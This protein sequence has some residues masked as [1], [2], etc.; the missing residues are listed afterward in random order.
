MDQARRRVCARSS[1]DKVIVISNCAISSV[2]VHHQPH[3]MLSC[4]EAEVVYGQSPPGLPAAAVG[5]SH[6]P[7]LVHPIK[8]HVKSAAISAGSDAHL[9]S[10][11]AIH[12]GVDGVPQPFACSGPTDIESAARVSRGF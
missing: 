4:G 6:R 8:L 12:Q 1:Q 2:A 5:I 7:G 10:V 11:T 3:D 9:E